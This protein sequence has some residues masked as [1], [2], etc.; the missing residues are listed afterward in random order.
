VLE[1]VK[2]GEELAPSGDAEETERRRER[3]KLH[4]E[5]VIAPVLRNGI[6]QRA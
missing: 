1:L 2:V 4:R 6:C 5:Q 3:L